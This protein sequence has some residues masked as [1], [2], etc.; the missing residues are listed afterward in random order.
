MTS[1]VEGL[2]NASIEAQHFGIPVVIAAVGGA[3]ETIAE[4]ITGVSVTGDEPDKFADAV[5]RFLE[6][7]DL[8]KMARQA[9]PAFVADTFSVDRMLQRSIE[10]YKLDRV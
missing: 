2:P 4:G 3:P 1:R 10:I 5:M 9:A 7:P 8:A 6:N